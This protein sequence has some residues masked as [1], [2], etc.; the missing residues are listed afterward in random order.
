MM[1]MNVTP[2]RAIGN[3]PKFFAPSTSGGIILK[4]YSKEDRATSIEIVN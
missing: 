2:I 1:S 3:V 4:G